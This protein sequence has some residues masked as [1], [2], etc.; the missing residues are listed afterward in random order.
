MQFHTGI[1]SL[2]S[3]M[4][5]D[6]V[7]EKRFYILLNKRD[8]K[9]MEF[10]YDQYVSV[11]YGVVF[12]IAGNEALAESLL[13]RTFHYIWKNYKEFDPDRQN[14]CVWILNVARKVCG[15]QVGFKE[16]TASISTNGSPS[17]HKREGVFDLL[18]FGNGSVADVAKHKGVNEAK[19]KMSLRGEMETLKQLTEKV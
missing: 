18:F 12:R 2:N 11:I 14:V 15:M 17:H 1:F 3:S 16:F 13:E 6:K 9:A 10:L 8:K 4:Q 19:I 7:N 5:A